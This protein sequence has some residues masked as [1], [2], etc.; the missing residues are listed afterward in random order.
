MYRYSLLLK[1]IFSISKIG[2]YIFPNPIRAKRTP[3]ENRGPN[4]KFPRYFV[5]YQSRYKHTVSIHRM[6]YQVDLIVD[7]RDYLGS[8]FTYTNAYE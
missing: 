2:D 4:L 5:Q 1:A 3:S 8:E 6:S 7:P